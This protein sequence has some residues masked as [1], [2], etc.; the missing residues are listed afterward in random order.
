[1]G[2]IRVGPQLIGIDPFAGGGL[3]NIARQIASHDFPTHASMDDSSSRMETVFD[4][5]S[6]VCTRRSNNL[7]VTSL[8]SNKK[9]EK[10]WYKTSLDS[11]VP[12]RKTRDNER[13][14]KEIVPKFPVAVLRRISSTKSDYKSFQLECNEVTIERSKENSFVIKHTRISRKHAVFRL[15]NGQ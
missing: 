5:D 3:Y 7:S 10:A 14:H 4:I 15:N 8:H 13:M 9:K 11:P 6:S 1:M 2:G 12:G